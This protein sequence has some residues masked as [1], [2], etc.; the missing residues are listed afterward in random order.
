MVFILPFEEQYRVPI[1]V[2]QRILRIELKKHAAF[3]CSNSWQEHHRGK[4]GEDIRGLPFRAHQAEQHPRRRHPERH[5]REAPRAP[6]VQDPAQ[7]RRGAQLAPG[8]GHLG[9]AC[10]PQDE[11]P[12]RGGQGEHHDHQ[13]Q[14]L[15]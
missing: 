3:I 4:E 15:S 1:L 7:E 8:L 12:H 10:G 6:A 2:M 13:N 14:R 11:D 9:E 5:K